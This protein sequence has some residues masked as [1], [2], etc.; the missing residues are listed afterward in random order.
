MFAVDTGVSCPWCLHDLSRLQQD[1]RSAPT[2]STAQKAFCDEHGWTSLIYALDSKYVPHF[3]VTK[4]VPQDIMHLEGDGILSHEAAWF[5]YVAVRKRGWFTLDELNASISTYAWPNGYRIPNVL[6][7]VIK[8]TKAGLP[9]HDAN[10]HFSAS[11]MFVFALNRSMTCCHYVYMK[12]AILPHAHVDSVSSSPLVGCPTWCPNC[13]VCCVKLCVF[14][15]GLMYNL[16]SVVLFRMLIKLD[17]ADLAADLAWASWVRHIEYV[18]VM[19]QHTFTRNEV[20]LLDKLIFEHQV[21]FAKVKIYLFVV[22]CL[23]CTL[24]AM[25]VVDTQVAIC[26]CKYVMPHAGAGVCHLPAVQ[27]SRRN[28]RCD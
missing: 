19:L 5:I 2:T 1:V 20:I 7:A 26:G 27:A 22:A 14:A 21:L 24:P 17:D 12:L 11:Q 6:P 15:C 8:G 4:M 28:A 25:C 18:N 9:K 13:V 10:L 16:S 3:D 23:F